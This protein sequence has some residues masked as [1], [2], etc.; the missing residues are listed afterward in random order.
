MWRNGG[1]YLKTKIYYITKKITELRISETITLQLQS[2][3]KLYLLFYS[4]I[5]PIIFFHVFYH[6]IIAEW[7]KKNSPILS[8]VMCILTSYLAFAFFSFSL[9]LS[10]T[11]DTLSNV[12][13][14]RKRKSRNKT[15]KEFFIYYILIVSHI[16]WGFNWQTYYNNVTIVIKSGMHM[17]IPYYFEINSFSFYCNTKFRFRF[18]TYSFYS[19]QSESSWMR[20]SHV[21]LTLSLIS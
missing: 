11:H 19:W 20:L 12:K 10:G 6:S 1:F 8:V 15:N 14:N 16:L 17:T 7:R 18:V 5:Q 13:K 4:V 3:T 2:K 21:L 9:F